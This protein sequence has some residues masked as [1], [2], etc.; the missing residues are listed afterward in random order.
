[1]GLYFSL[2]YIYFI[3][4]FVGRPVGDLD[5]VLANIFKAKLKERYLY[6]HRMSRLHPRPFKSGPS[7][8]HQYLDSSLEQFRC[9]AKFENHHF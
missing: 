3:G 9:V 8:L 4:S 6:I 2:A 1:M 7:P 5:L